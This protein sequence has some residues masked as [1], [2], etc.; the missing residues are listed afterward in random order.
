MNGR[1]WAR[2]TRFAK[3]T[4]GL[5]LRD[6]SPLEKHSFRESPSHASERDAADGAPCLPGH[7]GAT[8]ASFAGRHTPGH[9]AGVC[10][11]ALGHLT[12][13]GADGHLAAAG[14]GAI[15]RPPQLELARIWD[16]C[17]LL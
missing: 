7:S 4:F 12:R 17:R 1:T 9:L 15:A 16:A 13:D 5:A 6:T 10:A 2:C 3:L 14:A 11:G 8:A